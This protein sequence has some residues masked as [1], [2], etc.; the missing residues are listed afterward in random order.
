MARSYRPPLMESAASMAARE[1]LAQASSTF[2]IGM[3]V[4]PTSE[5]VR[6]PVPT[7]WTTCP[8]KP[9]WTSLN[10]TPASFRAARAAT[11]ASSPTLFSGCRP[12]GCRP[13]PSIT[14]RSPMVT[15][16]STGSG[17]ALRRTKLERHDVVTLAVH[18]GLLD[19]QLQR[20]PDAHGLRIDIGQHCG[21]VHPLGQPHLGDDVWRCHQRAW[22]RRPRD[23]EGPELAARGKR[24]LFQP[25]LV[26]VETDVARRVE[27]LA[28]LRAAAPHQRRRL[29]QAEA[30]A[31]DGDL[32]S[33][34][35]RFLHLQ[36]PRAFRPR[37][38]PWRGRL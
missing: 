27:V 32:C 22:E 18:A 34:G 29:P 36:P 38:A 23:G 20:H 9:A 5:K 15:P 35:R 7:P 25:F 26:A 8:Q 37:A 14:T 33:F 4:I 10:S 21:D 24:H 12:K 13:T 30:G 19:D 1:L 11:R 6:R 28:A 17:Q 31:L 3:P 16:P 2:V